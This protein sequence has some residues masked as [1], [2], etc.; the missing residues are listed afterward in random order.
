MIEKKNEIA[1]FEEFRIKTNIISNKQIKNHFP[2]E[3]SLKR[4]NV[5][6]NVDKKNK[7]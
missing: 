3:D 7:P 5:L 1:I 6:C 4:L 2:N